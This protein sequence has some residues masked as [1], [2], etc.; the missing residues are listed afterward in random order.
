[1]QTT[2]AADL[3]CG[4]GGTS[5]GLLLAAKELGLNISLTAVNHWDVAI[6][7]HSK[8]H[9]RVNHFNS[10]LE[11]LSPREAV[12]SGRLRLLVA[13]PECTNFSRAKGGA[14]KNKQSRASI[15]YILKWINQLDQVDDILIEN[16]P[17]FVEFGPL[18]RQCTCGAGPTL[19]KKHDKK[20]RYAT[21]IQSRKGEYFLRFIHKLEEADYSVKWR[22]L[23]AADYGDATTRK[24]LFI[25][26]RKGLIATFP[27]PTHGRTT[28][29]MLGDRPAWRSASEI[30]DWNVKGTSIF[31]RKHP[32]KENTMRRIEQGLKKFSG[33]AFVVGQQSK[34][35][36][37]DIHTP[38][39][40]IASKGAIALIQPY[41][42]SLRGTGESNLKS[43]HRSVNEP[44]PTVT[45]GRGHFYLTVPFLMEL[46]HGG[47]L[48]SLDQPMNTITS[49]DAWGLVQPFLVEYYGTGSA[50]SV[51]LPL[52]TQ[53]GRDRFGLAQPVIKIEGKKYKLDILYR[54]LTP[55]ELARAMSFPD[56]YQFTGTR[57]N[58]VKQIGN[59]VPVQVARALCKH[60]L[61]TRLSTEKVYQPVHCVRE[62]V[63]AWDVV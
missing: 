55:R 4:A 22:A 50:S 51:H 52:K 47:R 32:L 35:A 14:P 44:L 61:S 41:I 33:E 11:R 60:L 19:E 31:S 8:N 18:H 21:P 25:I 7:T 48:H 45:G 12:P 53:T 62:P 58:I 3:F 5:T 29:D 9:P 49:A 28:R 26:A 57:E 59:A 38:I 43:S 40:T 17:E 10:G 56:E 23:N 20:C 16:V 13:S 30:I 1:M 63:P 36:P 27:E 6:A 42:V 46:T 24:R 39:P 54:M 34:A 15:K 37:R 2:N